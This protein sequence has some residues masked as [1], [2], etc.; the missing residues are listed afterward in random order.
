MEEEEAVQEKST[1]T[2]KEKR[3]QKIKEQLLDEAFKKAEIKRGLRFFDDKSPKKSYEKTFPKL[4]VLLIV[5]SIFGLIFINNAPWAFIKYNTDYGSVDAYI[6]RDFDERNNEYP[7]IIKLFETP[8]YM[9][10]SIFDFTN[11]PS[12]AFN[13]FVSLIILGLLIT[14]LGIIDKKFNFS[15]QTFT[16]FHFIFAS[17]AIIPCIFIVISVMNFLS[18]HLL[19]FYNISQINQLIPNITFTFL[20]FPA[21]FLLVALG[22]II[23]KIEFT[24]MKV[25]L[26]ELQKLSQIDKPA[27]KKP[28]SNYVLGGQSQ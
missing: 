21:A 4:G 2:L 7:E 25:D 1:P 3:E 11:T 5:L 18:A 16:L 8:Y 23:I 12:L 14:I 24:V 10:L 6:Y 26:N 22:F 9:G 15:I 17:V 19:L 20:T 28:F 27:L 13:G